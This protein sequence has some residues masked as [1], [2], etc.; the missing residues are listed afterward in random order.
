MNMSK[1]LMIVLVEGTIG[2]GKST[3]LS[4]L[5]GK[6][7]V[8]HE[9]LEQWTDIKDDDGSNLFVKFCGDMQRYGFAFQLFVLQ[10]RFELMRK[11]VDQHSEGDVLFMERSVLSDYHI[12]AD[13]LHR[14]K[15]ISNLEMQV[16][17]QW[18]NALEALY[19]THIKGILYLRVEPLV[20]INRIQKRARKGEEK[21][22]LEYLEQLHAQHERWL[23]NEAKYPVKVIDASNEVTLEE[24][25]QFVD[26]L[27]L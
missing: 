24:V 25:D 11:A 16:Y 22:N 27:R 1:K 14:N 8:V 17:M 18:F 12:F 15:C 20:A 10:T 9:P 2:A 23:T 6:Y 21:Y 3:L 7:K 19:S 13:Q 4:R 26:S 5:E